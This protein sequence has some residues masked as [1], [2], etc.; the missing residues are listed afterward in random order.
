MKKRTSAVATSTTTI[1]AQN[2]TTLAPGDKVH[3]QHPEMG[4]FQAVVDDKTHD[5]HAIWILR[6]DL[7]E[8]RVFT[9]LEGVRLVPKT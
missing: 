3:V 9:N 4:K 8:R 5:S 6:E 7:G 1:D 2:W